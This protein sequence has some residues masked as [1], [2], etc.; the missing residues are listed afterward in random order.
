MTAGTAPINISGNASSSNAVKAG[1]MT[2]P[3]FAFFLNG[4]IVAPV[5]GNY[6]N[7]VDAMTDYLSWCPTPSANTPCLLK[8]MPGVYNIGA[9]SLQMRQYIDIE[10]SGENVTVIK[11]N[12]DSATAGVVNGAT[13]AE[14]RSLTV[15]H[16]GGGS[17][18]VAIYNRN[19]SPA[20]TNLKVNA[21]GSSNNYGIYNLASGL[22]QAS[23][24]MTKIA[25]N[26]SGGA[27]SFNY[28]VYN[29]GTDAIPGASPTMTSV[30]ILIHGVLFSPPTST[31]GV[32]NNDISSLVMTN[33]TAS[34]YDGTNNYGVFNATAGTVE[35]RHSVIS[36]TTNTIRN[37]S[38]VTTY[39]ALSQLDGGPVSNAGTLRCAGV[40]D[41]NYLLQVTACP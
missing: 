38:G 37:G 36:G 22:G 20:L 27:G 31:Y 24:I 8:I 33:V 17:N 26:V 13:L 29:D 28:G 30:S 23:S 6:T 3:P 9:A 4:A 14:L 32:Y 16:T 34:A 40:Y 21:S 5:G 7:P 2:A 1:G 10:G 15:T 35:I 18:A 11:G 39:V 41:E 25:V 12:I 19:S